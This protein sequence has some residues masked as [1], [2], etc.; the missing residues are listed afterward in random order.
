[1]NK[2]I[3][4]AKQLL[5]IAAQLKNAD[6][7]Q[8]KSQINH[9]SGY[10]GKLFDDVIM[11]FEELGYSINSNKPGEYDKKWWQILRDEY[12]PKEVENN[13]LD[14][15]NSNDLV[16]AVSKLNEF[17][18]CT[19][20]LNEIYDALQGNI[21]GE[22]T[23]SELKEMSK[24]LED[25]NKEFTKTL[26]GLV[27][28]VNALDRMIKKTG[29]GSIGNAF[30]NN[31]VLQKSMKDDKSL[32][33]DLQ[34]ISESLED[35][36]KEIEG[37][38]SQSDKED[39][40]IVSAHWNK[41]KDK[42]KSDRKKIK[43]IKTNYKFTKGLAEKIQETLA[44]PSKLK[45]ETPE[46]KKQQEETKQEPNAEETKQNDDNKILEEMEKY[47]NKVTTKL[48]NLDS[49]KNKII[50]NIIQGS[51]PTIKQHY[52]QGKKEKDFKNLVKQ[53]LDKSFENIEN[54]FNEK[55]Y[56]ELKNNIK[57]T[58]AIRTEFVNTLFKKSKDVLTEDGYKDGASSSLGSL[59]KQHVK[60]ED[61]DELQK[62]F[63]KMVEDFKTNEY[64]FSVKRLSRIAKNIVRDLMK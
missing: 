23:E 60:K 12:S 41:D 54:S 64:D 39:K 18:K 32:K 6:F 56:S 10:D 5:K 53:T 36:K 62:N 17:K 33:N 13:I 44:D 46:E 3:Q 20:E 31:K 9:S 43:D 37:Y 34:D 1:M 49:I 35:V 19:D 27:M 7:D 21:D 22:Y 38:I 14:Y 51:R 28:S 63:N 16:V 61:F 15:I 11:E 29:D 52:Q 57:D 30:K 55:K 24:A 8:L 50:D 25:L 4:I 59:L 47:S 58:N 26:K 2:R 45:P 42:Q 48:F 40:I